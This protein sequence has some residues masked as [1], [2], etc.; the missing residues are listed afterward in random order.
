MAS[1]GGWRAWW[2][3]RMDDAF[4]SSLRVTLALS[5]VMAA[6]LLLDQTASAIPLLLGVIASALAET[7]DSWRGRLSAQLAT[8][9]CFALI[10]WAVRSSLSHPAG[11][12]LVLVAAAFLLTLLGALGERYRAIASATL[13]MALYAV[14]AAQPQASR[15]LAPGQEL[16]L[17]GGAAWHGLVSVAWAAAFPRLAVEQNLARLYAA[18]GQYLELK[19]R[20]FEPVRGID[21]EQRR[22]ALAL[23]NGRVVDALNAVK[24]SVFSRRSAKHAQDW[25]ITALHQFFVAQDVHERTSSS[26]EHYELLANT[27]FHSDVL[28][29]CQ[30]VLALLGKDCLSLAEALRRQQTWSRD[31]ATARAIDDLDAAIAHLDT[32]SAPISGELGQRSRHALGALAANLAAM[33]A[34]ISGVQ[35]RQ[36][37]RM[38]A[39]SA[40]QDSQPRTP[41]QFRDRLRAQMTIGSPLMRH[42]IRLSVALMAGYAL[43]RITG[44]SYGFWTLLTI[45]FVC[46]PHYGATL[47]RL[48]E[49]IAGT[50][51]GLVIGWALLKLFP[52]PLLQALF[53]VA[54]TVVFFMLRSTRYTLATA[55]ITIFVLLSFN[56]VGDGYG[57]IVPRLLDTLS[58]SL[59]AALAV[60]LV[61][62]SWNSLRLPRLAAE[63]LRTQSRYLD[64]IMAQYGVG[65]KHDNLAYRI[66]RRDAHNADAALSGA[67]TAA[68]K[69]PRYVRRP[70]ESAGTRF[71]VLSH[72]LLNYLSALGAHRNAQL[73]PLDDIARAA[74]GLHAAL[75]EIAAALTS[76]Q[77]MAQLAEPTPVRHP[78]AGGDR[79]SGRMLRAQLDLALRLL[80]SLRVSARELGRRG[81]GE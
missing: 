22:L 48:S 72:T 30:R 38:P 68:L 37:Q 80:P 44:D 33:S 74:D 2:H 14:L 50:L 49:R 62:P 71:L 24:E 29:R 60:W 66:A 39:D 28:Y 5:A 79:E 58:G 41:G 9:L 65:G 70:V 35:Q 7:D 8:L 63:A 76:G 64:A 81:A 53:I 47:T 17:L 69:E 61:L 19:S 4:S 36:T 26:H 56:Q 77:A 3:D 11:L 25:L 59:I 10:I 40:L 57:L 13:I 45:V 55:G 51:L 78:P 54:A 75:E 20:L 43:M 12:L 34:E 31:G 1:S 73:P 23:H 21:L 42:A 46:Q 27:F 52:D 18:L 16:L 32:A 6:C 15:T 67:L